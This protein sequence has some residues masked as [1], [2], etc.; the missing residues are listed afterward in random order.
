MT[1]Q[2]VFDK[3]NLG[4]STPYSSARPGRGCPRQVFALG[5]SHSGP[6]TGH[7]L[8]VSTSLLEFI[9]LM[10]EKNHDS[11]TTGISLKLG[12]PVLVVIRCPVG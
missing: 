1:S 8:L 4:S 10:Y 3:P 9:A 7:L 5:W 2:I 12:F 11:V 6:V